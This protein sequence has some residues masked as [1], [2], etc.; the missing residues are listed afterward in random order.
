MKSYLFFM[1]LLFFTQVKAQVRT[2]QFVNRTDLLE[3]Y[4]Y[5]LHFPISDTCDTCT[6][7]NCDTCASYLSDLSKFV[8]LRVENVSRK[9][10]D[11]LLKMLPQLT[12]VRT[13]Q[14]RCI[15]GRYVQIFQEIEKLDKLEYVEFES[16]VFS[17]ADLDSIDFSF[18]LSKLKKIKYLSIISFNLS[19]IPPEIGQLTQLRQLNIADNDFAE[20]PKE[21]ANLHNLKILRVGVLAR[22]EKKFT[23]KVQHISEAILGLPNLEDLT[24]ISPDLREI[25]CGLMDMPKLKRI[26]IRQ[27]KYITEKPDCI[28]ENKFD[29][30][31]VYTSSY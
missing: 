31:Y 5:S 20:F 8:D 1:F 7:A 29:Y 25:P 4:C 11:D 21:F 9:D 22:F 6:Y 2:S 17:N 3:N 26:V 18:I 10:V 23:S 19:V 30:F 27:N 15:P 16:Y 28:D 12:E 13:I 24:I 14:F